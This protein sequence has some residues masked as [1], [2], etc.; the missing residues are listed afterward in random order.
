[1]R[2]LGEGGGKAAI[3]GGGLYSTILGLATGV[4]TSLR[5]AAIGSRNRADTFVLLLAG[6]FFLDGNVDHSASGLWREATSNASLDEGSIVRT[7]LNL[8]RGGEGEEVGDLRVR[9]SGVNS[10]CVLGI[11]AT[12]GGLTEIE[13][14]DDNQVGIGS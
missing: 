8:Q 5:V 9:F 2:G 7:D 12:V 10:R 3:R 13:R 14:A 4:S 11:A 1:M 6:A